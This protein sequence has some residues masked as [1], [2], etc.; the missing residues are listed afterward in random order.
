MSN[1]DSPERLP[2]GVPG[3]DEIL[4]GGL[5][6]RAAYLVRGG[7]GQGKT[8]LGLHFLTAA[9]DEPALFIGFQEPEEQLRANAASVGLDVA[10]VNFLSLAPDE[11]FFTQQQGYDVFAAADVEQAPLAETVVEA[12][13]RHAPTRVFVDSLTQLRFLSTDIFQYRKQVLSFLRYLRE[14]GATVLFSSESSAELPDDDLQFISDGVMAL[15]SDPMGATVR[16]TKFRGSGFR[17]GAHQMRLNADG[18]QVFPRPLPPPVK[19]TD[20]EPWRWSSGVPK[21]DAILHG[22]VEAGTVS[23]LTG[24]SGIGKS[25]LASLFL[26]QAVRDGKRAAVFLFEEEINTYLR[27]ARALGV[28]LDE[29]F[30]AGRVTIEQ[31]DPM[32][33]LAD[34]FAMRVREY[35]AEEGVELVVLDSISGFELTLQGDELKARLHAFAKGLARLGVSV[36]LINEVE[37]MTGQFRV[38][39]KGISYLSDNVLVLRYMETDGELRKALGVLKK[40]LSGF[41]GRLYTF[42]VRAPEGLAVGDPIEGLSGVLMGTP[43]RHEEP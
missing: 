12:V 8:T 36:L 23:L 25:T 39:E 33:Y 32:R 31:I 34:E 43:V 21:I 42:Q 13:T 5:I 15:D 18:L 3:L 26:A 19:V 17:R 9:S 27:R 37:A 16:V 40:R 20:D 14:R 41:D 22:G 28:G 29:P 24:P 35:V 11:E 30:K 1:E 6:P 10:R 7:P 4:D 2:T 38:S